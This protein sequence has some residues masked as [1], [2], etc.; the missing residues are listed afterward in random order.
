MRFI[1][2]VLLIIG[3]AALAADTYL[4]FSGEQLLATG[5]SSG[6]GLTSVGSFRFHAFAEYWNALH[7]NSLVGFS[8]FLERTFGAEIFVDYLLP[9][10]AFPAF[11]LFFVPGALIM[12]I[13]RGR[14]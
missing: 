8:A 11:A 5:S 13:F 7:P 14:R 2:A 12:L 3:V 4:F 9:V 10:F 1:G 6:A